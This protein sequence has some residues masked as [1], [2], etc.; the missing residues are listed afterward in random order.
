[1][2]FLE[3]C[4]ACR[5]V[6][7]ERCGEIVA[8]TDDVIVAVNPFSIH[9]GHALVMPRRH[10]VNIYQLPD[11]VAGPILSMAARVARAAKAAFGAGGITLRQNNEPASDQHL[12]H[13]PLHV[14]RRFEGD[15]ERFAANP[16]LSSPAE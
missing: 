12:F 6:S 8:E 16:P 15:A 5:L 3:P 13:S 9:P 2:S 4:W 14:I 7:G 10:I 11:D 1:M